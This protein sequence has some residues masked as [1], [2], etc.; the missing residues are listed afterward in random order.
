[1]NAGLAPLLTSLSPA[2]APIGQSVV[3][4]GNSFGA[5]QGTSTLTVAGITATATAWS[6]TSVTFTVP[7]TATGAVVMTVNGRTSNT[8]TFTVTA[9]GAPSGE[10]IYLAAT[11]AGGNTG[12]NCANAKAYTFFNSATNW[13]ATV[14]PSD[15]KISPGDT[16]HLCGTFTGTAGTT[17]LTFQGSGLSGNPITLLFESGAI[18]QAPYWSTTTG[19]I[20][21]NTKNFF[22]IDGGTNGIVKNTA[23]GTALANQQESIGLRLI[24]SN[25]YTVQNLTISDIYVRIAGTASTIGQDSTAISSDEGHDILITHNTMTNV[26]VGVGYQFN[27]GTFANLDVSFNTFTGI[28]VPVVVASAVAN[29][30]LTGFL[31]HDNDFAGGSD[32]WDQGVSANDFH[33]EALHMFAQATNAHVVAPRVYNNY[34]HGIWGSDT[35]YFMATG[36]T[37]VTTLLY[38]E[39]V[40]GVAYI[41]NNILDLSTGGNTN[42]TDN[43]MVFCKNDP[44]Q[45]CEVYNNTFIQH[46]LDIGYGMQETSNGDQIKN[47]IFK[48]VNYPI[49]T[50][51]GETTV[52]ADYNLYFGASN[53]GIFDSY[54]MWQGF[55]QDA[56]GKNGLDPLL[57]GTFHPGVSSPAFL[58]GLN[59][60][61]L[62]IATLNS[63]KAGVARPS[64]ATLWTAGAYQQ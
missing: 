32:L 24:G 14:L 31:M 22:T 17:L 38:F 13:S 63:D 39:E 64:G 61:S 3:I 36:G 25:N 15:G 48:N 41:Y 42:Q 4:A 12:A 60:T 56:H 21:G 62:G 23:N 29:T 52:T 50:P 19:A 34:I 28:E 26:R 44:A 7:T 37:H 51:N 53:W 8:L 45:H 9:G 16:V 43:G 10:Q 59:L 54:A 46:G 47:N 20:Y 40:G 2:S 33:H 6:N 58:M 35:A 1:V 11:F 57:S 55:G 49:Y 5:T 30:T 27:T 18:L